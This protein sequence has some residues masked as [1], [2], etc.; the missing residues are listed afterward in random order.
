MES[1]QKPDSQSGEESD[2]SSLAHLLRS[3]ADTVCKQAT[4][5]A[6]LARE[7][8]VHEKNRLLQMLMVT[9]LGFTLLLCI[10]LTVSTFILLLT[11]QTNYKFHA[12]VGLIAFYLIGICFSYYRFNTLSSRSDQAFSATRKALADDIALIKK[13][14]QEGNSSATS[15]YPRSKTMRFLVLHPGVKIITKIILLAVGKRF[16]RKMM[17]IFS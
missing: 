7:E 2:S 9:L 17:S 5:H 6:Q 12:V 4:K 13:S 16:F 15:T 14:L 8:W 1:L 10:L 3:T 11:W